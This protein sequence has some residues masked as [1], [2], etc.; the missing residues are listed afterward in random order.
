MRI[1]IINN[2]NNF[3]ESLL[4]GDY[5]SIYESAVNNLSRGE[6]VTSRRINYDEATFN[7]NMK[8]IVQAIIFGHPELFF[9]DPKVA[10]EYSNRGEATLTFNSL[11]NKKELEEN[12][13]YLI[14]K[15]NEIVKEL[16][17]HTNKEDIIYALN[18]YLCLHFTGENEYTNNNGNAF[19]V[20]L[21]G[22][23]RCEGFCKI[24]KLVLDRFNIENII[25]TGQIEENGSHSPHAWLAIKYNDN[26]YAFDF[27]F[28]CSASFSTCPCRAY[29]F[30]N[31]QYL[32]V[33][34]TSDYSYPITDDSSLLFWNLHNGETY[35]LRDLGNADIINF[36]NNYFSI[37]HLDLNI[38]IGDYQI[39]Y[40]IPNWINENLSPFSYGYTYLYHYLDRLNALVIYYIN[41]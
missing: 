20:F 41:D 2:T 24:A 29:T 37:H 34:R 32:Y 30:L 22:K 38:D 17:E 27:S 26:Y 4:S 5:L 33:G 31:N 14:N 7:A 11:Y 15:I 19:G 21:E 6:F 18:D 23:A 36:R 8:N 16:E 1:E 35:D 40:E 25:C 28:N 13:K 10:I 9:I 3:Y 12:N 39:T